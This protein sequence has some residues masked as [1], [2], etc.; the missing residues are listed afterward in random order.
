MERVARWLEHHV[1]AKEIRDLAKENDVPVGML[2]QAM[3]RASQ[4]KEFQ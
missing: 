4:M 1:D 3:A 2:R